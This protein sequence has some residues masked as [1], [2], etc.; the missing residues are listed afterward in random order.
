MPGALDTDLYELTMAASFLRRG[1]VGPATFSL[2]VRSLPPSRGFLVASGVDDALDALASLSFTPDDLDHLGR[3][4]FDD[5]AV[6]AFASLRFTGEVWAVPEGTVVF[7][8]EP[9]LEVT[10][11]IAEAQLVETLLLN[12]VTFH[13]TA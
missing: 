11:P 12:V 10:A 9:L 4:G 2:F 13:T 3:L 5:E 6:Q 8:G 7:A 1:M